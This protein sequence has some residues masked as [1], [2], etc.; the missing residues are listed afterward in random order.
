M[1]WVAMFIVA[2]PVLFWVVVWLVELLDPEPCS[3]RCGRLFMLSGGE[4]VDGLGTVHGLERCQP[5]EEAL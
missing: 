5:R 4:C 1:G 3:C 2:V